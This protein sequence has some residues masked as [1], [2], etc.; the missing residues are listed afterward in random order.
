MPSLPTKRRCIAQPEY[1]E[2]PALTAPGRSQGEKGT[3]KQGTL[4]PLISEL[5]TLARGVKQLELAIDS[6]I[7]KV[8]QQEK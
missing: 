2:Q 5:E 3:P 4:A 8:S 1:H 6:I 7:D